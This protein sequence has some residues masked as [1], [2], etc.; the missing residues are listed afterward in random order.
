MHFPHDFAWG[1]ATA[2]YQIEGSPN[3]DGKGLSV[4]D[5]Y[6]AEPGR[7]WDGHT[8]SVACDHY[9]RYR[10]DVALMKRIGLKAYRFSV[11]WPRVLPEGVGRVNAAGLD[12]YDRLV[13]EL[14]AAGVEPWITL[15]HWDY[16][17]A[18]FLRGGWLNPDCPSW[19]SEYTSAVVSRLSDR[20]TRWITQNEPQV[21]IGMGHK[22]GTH[23]PGMRY[24][25]REIILASHHA[26]KAHGLSVRAIRAEAKRKPVVGFAPVGIGSTPAG[27]SPADIEAARAITF[28]IPDDGIWNSAWWMDPVAL[29]SYPRAGLDRFERHLPTGWEKDMPLISEPI[30]FLGAN[31]YV[32]SRTRASAEGAP[33]NVPYPTHTPYTLMHWKWTPESLYWVPRFLHERYRLPIVVTENGM[34][35]CDVVSP[36]GMVHDASRVEFLRLY[37][38][39]LG[40]AIA[41]GVRVDGYFLW[42]LMDNFEW[43]EGYR[44]RFGLVHV[45]YASQRRVIKDSGLW[46]ARVIESNGALLAS[47]GDPVGE[48]VLP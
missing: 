38:R 10:E 45:D 17:Y 2:S 36:D 41:D 18:L 33:E 31:I 40:R 19:F 13:D 7:I 39:E 44:Q 47:A 12:F 8:G 35:S 27:D 43:A 26:L 15:F 21:F 4:W 24:S 22:E 20:V 46:Y 14:L 42:S 3:A 25:T 16:P 6:C 1:A 9:R 30:D 37:L 5:A 29:G 23:A 34:S 48:P 11:C 32:A 28:A